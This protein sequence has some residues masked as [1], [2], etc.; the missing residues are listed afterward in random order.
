MIQL[1]RLNGEAFILNAILIEQI[2]ALPDTTITLL[3]GKKLVVKNTEKE[4]IQLV[5]AYYQ[6]IGLQSIHI[7]AGEEK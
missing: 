3:N 6:T 1:F 4:V 5:T 2:Q 7:E